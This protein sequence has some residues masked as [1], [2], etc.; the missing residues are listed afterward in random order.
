M[1][2]SKTAVL[3]RNLNST[4][5]NG[6]T[7][8]RKHRLLPK[9]TT[10]RNDLSSGKWYL[11]LFIFIWPKSFL[12]AV[13]WGNVFFSSNKVVH[14]RLICHWKDQY[15]RVCARLR[16]SD[17]R[18]EDSNQ[19]KSANRTVTIK[20][21]FKIYPL[22]LFLYVFLTNIF[23]YTHTH[24]HAPPTDRQ[25]TAARSEWDTPFSPLRCRVGGQRAAGDW[26]AS[27]HDLSAGWLGA[28]PLLYK[29]RKSI[30]SL[31]TEPAVVR[32]PVRLYGMCW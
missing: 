30:H 1:C 24:T 14:L 15:L 13:G 6:P 10:K 18:T 20:K 25:P 32:G 8:E 21:T 22:S 28:S 19:R 23:M 17:H 27:L 11:L 16:I 9:W 12:A 7:S 5:I 2:Q 29:C 26:P 4:V 31:H 3:W